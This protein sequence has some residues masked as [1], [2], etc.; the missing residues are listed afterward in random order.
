MNFVF[1]FLIANQFVDAVLQDPIASNKTLR[2]FFGGKIKIGLFFGPAETTRYPAASL[3]GFFRMHL[4]KDSWKLQPPR[5]YKEWGRGGVCLERLRA[6]QRR[7]IAVS[8]T[9]DPVE[10]GWCRGWCASC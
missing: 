7:R 4:A 6:R 9:L 3:A 8:P 1:L 2:N 10:K 5:G